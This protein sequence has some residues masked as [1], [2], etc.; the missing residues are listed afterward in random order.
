MKT[1]PEDKKRSAATRTKLKPATKHVKAKPAAE[2][3]KKVWDP[4]ALYF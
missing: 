4:C 2:K 1:K 3:P